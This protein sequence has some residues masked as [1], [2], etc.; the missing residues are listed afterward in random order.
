MPVQLT[1]HSLD[2][3]MASESSESSFNIAAIDP[4]QPFR[5][6]FSEFLNEPNDG[7]REALVRPQN[8]CGFNQN[9]NLYPCPA[10][11]LKLSHSE[12]HFL[13]CEWPSR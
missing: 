11:K 13:L 12:F 6:Q 7:C 1:L 2:R 9:G 4:H 5:I 10:V 3:R 8:F